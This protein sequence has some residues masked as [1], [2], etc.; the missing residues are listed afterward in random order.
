VIDSP[1]LTAMN[2]VKDSHRSQH[3]NSTY[4]GDTSDMGGIVGGGGQSDA[5]VSDAFVSDAFVGDAFVGDAFVGDALV[6]DAFAASDDT[7]VVGADM[8]IKTSK[9]KRDRIL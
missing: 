7:V 3:S 8:T 4:M 1:V 9:Q 2:S 6:S 5:F